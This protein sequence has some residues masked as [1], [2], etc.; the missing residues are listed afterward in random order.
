MHVVSPSTCSF[1]GSYS[2]KSFL[3]IQSRNIKKHGFLFNYSALLYHG[4]G[5][6]A[7]GQVPRYLLPQKVTLSNRLIAETDS[8]P[9]FLVNR[10]VK[11]QVPKIPTPQQIRVIKAPSY[12]CNLYMI[13]ESSSIYYWYYCV[14]SYH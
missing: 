13:N 8:P 3:R 4:C 7:R 9:F 12:G 2:R 6:D 14:L 5:Q 10:H 1:I 11:Q